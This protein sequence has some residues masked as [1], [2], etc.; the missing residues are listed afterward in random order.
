MNSSPLSVSQDAML[1]AFERETLSLLVVEDERSLADGCRAVA[2]IV[3]FRVFVAQDAGA[4]LRLFGQQSIDMVLLDEQLGVTRGLDLLREL[5]KRK[6]EVLVV[7]MT[8]FAT[9]EAAVQAMKAGAYDY[10]SKPFGLDQLRSVLS[11]SA[12]ELR[13]ISEEREMQQSLRTKNGF[14]PIIG[15]SPAMEKLFR[16]LGK[17]AQSTHPV[18]I[19]GE[20]GTGKEMVART[21]HFSGPRRDKPFIPVDCGALSPTLIESELFGHV[22]GAFTGASQA[23]EGLLSMAEGGALFFDEIGDLPL[24]VQPKLMRALQ[25]KQIRPIGGTRHHSIDVRILAATTRD[26]SGAVQHGTF[27]KD[28]F[29]HLNVVNMRVPPLR[30]RPED[31]PLLAGFFLERLNRANGTKPTLLFT[32]LRHMMRYEWPGNVRELENCISQAAA[33]STG[34]DVHIEDLPLQ[35]REFDP[36]QHLPVQRSEDEVIP[37]ATLERDA[38]YNAIERAK[39]DKQRAA[40][41]L[42]IGKTT[43]YRKLKQYDEASLHEAAT[44]E[45][46]GRTDRK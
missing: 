12:E 33:H 4:A 1:P 18:L 22:K 15:R 30:E 37:L 13:Y 43:L 42:G 19:L 35:I 23:K 39:G 29:L 34:S 31:I 40:T 11:R 2:E 44:K 32:A 25:E 3:G 26:L 46:S 45:T 16:L 5:R 38:I 24:E 8:G 41:L 27:R 20:S 17:V 14:G 36:N 21:I 9:V 7:V 28:L 6:P 10:I